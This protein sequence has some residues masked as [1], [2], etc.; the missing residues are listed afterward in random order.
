MQKTW[1]MQAFILSIFLNL[2]LIAVLC[3][4]MIKERPTRLFLSFRPYLGQLV[5]PPLDQ[6][7]YEELK[8]KAYPELVALLEDRTR[9]RAGYKTCDIAL[10]ILVKDYDM[11][12]GKALQRSLRSKIFFK[13]ALVFEGISRRDFKR[14]GLFIRTHRYPFTPSG[15]HRRL[16]ETADVFAQTEEYRILRALVRRLHPALCTPSTLLV[17]S[18]QLPWSMLENLYRQ[19][20]QKGELTEQRACEF[21]V[22]AVYTGSRTAAYLLVIHSPSH[23]LDEFDHA[24]VMHILALLDVKTQEAV[25]CCQS[26][27]HSQRPTAI[28]EQARHFLAKRV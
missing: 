27:V 15:L 23:S 17:L 14:I 13:D 19:Q 16:P 11:D 21:L 2:V 26:L 1:P 6:A 22:D 20:Q 12:I 3:F 24:T 5:V 25:A 9:L 18:Q 7:G 8:R 10:G 4:V 28:V